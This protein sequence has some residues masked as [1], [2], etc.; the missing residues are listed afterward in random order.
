VSGEVTHWRNLAHR[1]TADLL[2]TGM[3]LRL[4]TTARRIDPGGRKLL[5]TNPG[6]SEELIGYDK[7]LV[8]TGAVPV[9]PRIGGLSGPGALGAGDGVHLL[10][11]MGDTFAVMHT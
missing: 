2:A 10:H 1:T 4:D 3:S 11:S 5:V 6:G 8:G 9:V 7:L